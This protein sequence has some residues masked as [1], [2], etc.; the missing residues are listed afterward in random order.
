MIQ[1]EE[2]KDVSIQF[3]FFK[4]V[5]C[6]AQ[7]A[8]EDIHR[9]PMRQMRAN[10]VAFVVPC[11]AEGLDNVEITVSSV[12]IEAE[13]GNLLS[14]R[15]SFRKRVKRVLGWVSICDS[16]VPTAFKRCRFFVGKF[17]RDSLNGSGSY[18]R[19]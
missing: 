14:S 5:T 18:L 9:G 7:V 8:S 16:C 15:R 1:F 13:E 12:V 2:R 10:V 4:Q 19:I 3:T 6:F 11:G 17:E